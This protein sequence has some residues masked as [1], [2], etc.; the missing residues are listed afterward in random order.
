MSVDLPT[1]SKATQLYS[2][3]VRRERTCQYKHTL[4]NFITIFIKFGATARSGPGPPHHEVS[5]SH[6][7][8]HHIR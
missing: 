1:A 6:T 5:R 8:T 7:T 2:D 4:Q 3:K